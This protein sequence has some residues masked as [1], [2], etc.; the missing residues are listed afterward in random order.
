MRY[1]LYYYAH[2]KLYDFVPLITKQ[3][4]TAH[5]KVYSST[6]IKSKQNQRDSLHKYTSVHNEKNS[7][8]SK[9]PGC[10]CKEISLLK[11][12]FALHYRR[13]T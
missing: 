2:E 10:K 5:S 1:R 12:C 13:S 9:L 4:H 11:K 7:K 3:N 8:C 6:T